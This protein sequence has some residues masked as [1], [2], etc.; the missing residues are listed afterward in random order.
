MKNDG[1]NGNIAAINTSSNLEAISLKAV[2]FDLDGTILDSEWFYFRGWKAVLEEEYGLAL[3]S[4][5]WL[6]SLAGKTDGQAFEMLQETYGFDVNADE[7]HQRKQARIAKQYE[8][9]VV[10]L[11]PGVGEL[12]AYLRQQQVL[13][14]V[15]TS[16]KRPVTEYN[17]A[18]HGLLDAFSF[19]VTR[20]E[21]THPKPN[22]EP[23]QRCVEQFGLANAE[24]IVLEDS[25][26]G[27]TAA[28]AAGLACYGVQSHEE[29]RRALTMV[30]RLFFDL[31]EV[32]E[33][34]K[35]TSP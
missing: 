17:L 10:Q 24:C 12:V 27:A 3:D 8:T 18:K 23:Y 13:L 28:K 30:D 32:L 5:L 15:V 21:V 9:E 7:F 25:V 16:S 31:H 6:T 22:P 26:T 4:H 14:A 33:F 34:M 29:I 20:S 2:L 35:N 1:I 19:L 11:M